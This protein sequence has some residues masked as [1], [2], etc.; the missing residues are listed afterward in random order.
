[1]SKN[2]ILKEKIKFFKNLYFVRKAFSNLVT[3]RIFEKKELCLQN[4]AKFCFVFITH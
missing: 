2:M 3:D 1:M 4:T